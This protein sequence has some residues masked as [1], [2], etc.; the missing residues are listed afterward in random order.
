[1]KGLGRN[2]VVSTIWM[3]V[4][5][6][7]DA[8]DS[9]FNLIRSTKRIRSDETTM[10]LLEDAV[11]DYVVRCAASYLLIALI[12]GVLMHLFLRAWYPQPPS[13]K[14]WLSSALG[15]LGLSTGMLIGWQITGFPTLYDWFPARSWMAEQLQPSWWLWGAIGMVSVFL[16]GALRR[17]RAAGGGLKR[18]GLALVGLLATVALLQPLSASSPAQNQGPNVVMI[19]IDA[20]RPDRLSFYG[21]ERQT[22]PNIDAVLAESVIFEDAYTQLPRTYPAWITTLSGTWPT[23]HGIRD[24]LPTDDK[25]IPD[26][27]LLPQVMQDAGYTTGFATDDSR[28][29]YMVPQAGFDM[30]RQPQVGLANFAL[31]I[32]E[33]RFRLFHG[34]LHNPLGFAMVPVQAYNQSFGKSYR[35]QLFNE[36]VID[37]LAELSQSDK[38]FYAVHSCVLHAPGDRVHPWNNMFDQTGY[39]GRNRFKYSSSGSG[40]MVAE[41]EGAKGEKARRIADQDNRIYD[42]GIAMADALVG[43]VVASLKESGLW[44][45]TILVLFSDHGEEL[46]DTDLPYK[47]YGPNHGFHVYGDGHLKVLMAIRFPD[48]KLAGERVSQPVRLIDFA[49]TVAEMVGLQWPNA[50]DGRSMLSVARGEE[51]EDRLVYMETGLSEPRYWVKGHK[52]YPF[53]KVSKRYSVSEETGRVHIRPK[54]RDALI[55]NKERAVQVGQYKLIWHSLKSG[56]RVDLFDRSVDVL[57]RVDISELAPEKVEELGQLMVPFLAADGIQTA[58][59]SEWVERSRAPKRK[60]TRWTK[61]MKRNG[62]SLPPSATATDEPEE[63]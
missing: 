26:L 19:G 30:I 17:S 39:R 13:F 34:L 22:S 61:R 28:F 48:G 8:A 45:N 12:A 5:F 29:S 27:A 51:P 24:N 7:V 59:V 41:I 18:V 44:D 57:N 63:R 3:V 56:M 43:D 21:H 32:N 37:G 11:V 50:V 9:Y 36:Y 58:P 46:W 38:F 25:I 33:P 40:M 10:R 52:K 16:L 49:P 2:L 31:S 35:P 15:L 47:W 54:F 53:K 1:M 4:L 14:H 23:T 60:D 6:V 62:G 42:S 20:L 55:R